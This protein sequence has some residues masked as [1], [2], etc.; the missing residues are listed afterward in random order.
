M[1]M[2]IKP[3]FAKARPRASS[4]SI[5]YSVIDFLSMKPTLTMYLDFCD[6][7]TGSSSV[8]LTRTV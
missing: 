8:Q 1:P 2:Q 3:D 4:F 7:R 6:S 5:S